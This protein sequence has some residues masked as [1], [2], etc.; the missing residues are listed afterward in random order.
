LVDEK[1]GK[2]Y[3]NEVNPLPGSL[4]NHNWQRSGVSPVE[5]VQRLVQLAEERH[6]RR[7][8]LATAFSTNFLKQF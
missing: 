7:Q 3:F 6:S 4:Y 2:V 8:K 1:Q 5:L